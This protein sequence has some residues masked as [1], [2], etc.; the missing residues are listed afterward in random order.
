MPEINGELLAAVGGLLGAVMAGLKELSSW[1]NSRSHAAEERHS[2]DLAHKEMAF[3]SAWLAATTNLSSPELD[4]G[5]AQAMRHLASLVQPTASHL[6]RTPPP[7][8][9]VSLWL[10]MVFYIYSGFFVC[11]VLGASIDQKTNN[12]SIAALLTEDNLITLLVLA[13]PC[14]WLYRVRRKAQ[15]GD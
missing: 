2:L 3:I 13:L 10:N 12:F 5:R 7:L 8:K 11:S 9:P 14:I 4:A 6:Q 1:L 15:Q